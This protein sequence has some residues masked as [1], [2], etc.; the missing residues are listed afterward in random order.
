MACFAEKLSC[1]IAALLMASGGAAA[2]TVTT[3]LWDTAQGNIVTG[4]ST[5]GVYTGSDIRN[6]FGGTFGTIENNPGNTIFTD[7][8]IFGPG[9]VALVSWK[10]PDPVALERFVLAVAADG[11]NPYEPSTSTDP[12]KYNRSIQ[13]FNL[14]ASSGPLDVY[15]D[16]GKPIYSSGELKAPLG[17]FSGGLY[18]HTIDH[19]FSTPV[20]AQHFKADFVYGSY[21]TGPRIIELDGYGR[22]ATAPVPEPGT[23]LLLGAGLAGV[24]LWKRRRAT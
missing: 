13:G 6:M 7:A 16:W 15:A 18:F 3:D 20:S 1:T 19:T 10:T 22:T 5:A 9:A 12:Q 23:A 4:L 17:V 11:V 2:Q 8:Q 24:F 21:Y 14:Y